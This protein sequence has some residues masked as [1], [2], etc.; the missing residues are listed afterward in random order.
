M[1][2]RADTAAAQDGLT[3]QLIYRFPAKFHIL[4]SR[5][6][7]TTVARHRST[8][9]CRGAPA[10]ATTTCRD[11]SSSGVDRTGSSK[12]TFRGMVE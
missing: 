2:V 10:I 8:S 5:W 7:Q 6:L 11:A 9:L 3:P 12:V 1:A 4:K